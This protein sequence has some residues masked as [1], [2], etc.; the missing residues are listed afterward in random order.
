MEVVHSEPIDLERMADLCAVGIKRPAPAPRDRSTWHVS[1]L[2]DSAK[3][4]AKGDCSYHEFVGS[5]LGIMSWGRIWETSV[6]CYL[7]DYASRKSGFYLPDVERAR[8]GIVGSLD[9]LMALPDF[10]W[11][12]CETKLR[13]TL[14]TE[15]P[16]KHLQQVRAYC[17]MAHTDL[18]CY[19]SGH[20][21]STPPTAQASLRILRLTQQSIA[22]N[23]EM[24]VN[25]KHHLENRGLGPCNKGGN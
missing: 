2:I 17:Q 1:N 22:E 6:D 4:I 24:L 8:D 13:F 5:P 25:T 7:A 21:S 12:V 10:G 9:G 20:L 3:L 14:N 16:F 23:W 19:V 15:I 18:V 11:M